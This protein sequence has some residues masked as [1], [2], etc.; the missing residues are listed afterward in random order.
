MIM[1]WCWFMHWSSTRL[2]VWVVNGFW[3]ESYS[4]NTQGFK[5]ILKGDCIINH[6]I[7]SLVAAMFTFM[8]YFLLFNP[9]SFVLSACCPSH[10]QHSFVKMLT[11][12]LETKNVIVVLF[13]FF[14]SVHVSA[15]DSSCDP[16]V[17]LLSLCRRQEMWSQALTS[18]WNQLF[19][20][21]Q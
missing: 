11:I 5:C 2:Q 9:T 19:E 21:V 13:L 4:I 7:D 18:I 12:C 3:Q 1:I 17:H 14:P 10:K 15:T 16:L 20:F 6:I 8:S